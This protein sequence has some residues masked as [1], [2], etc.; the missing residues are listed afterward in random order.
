MT[1]DLVK[2]LSKPIRI[3]SVILTILMLAYVFFSLF[4][5]F[6]W[7]APSLDGRLDQH[8]AADSSTYIYIADV[9]RD[10]RPDPSVAVALAS[11]PN[12]LWVPVLLALVLKSTFA[13]VIA[14]Y[15]MFILALYLFKKSTPCSIATL[16]GLLLLNATTT[17]S[18]LSVNKE[19]VDLLVVSLFIFARRKRSYTLLF[20]VLLLALFNRFEV[21]MV[22]FLFMFVESRMNP[23]RQNR[24][25][26]IIVLLVVLSVLLPLMASRTLAA[27][28][29]EASTSNTI[30]FLDILEMHYLYGLAVIPKIAENL[31]AELINVSKW[32]HSYSLS[33]LAN[34]YIV[35]SNNLATF[36][37]FIVLSS[38]RAL[39]LRS[40]LIYFAT[41]GS[42][43][44][45][46]ALVVQ[47]RY[48]Y[49]VYVVL[50]L[51]AA[52]PKEYRRSGD[53]RLSRRCEE[54]G[55]CPS[56]S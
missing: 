18:L 9:L 47:P 11:F 35:L 29:E 13:M 30:T 6:Q 4:L 20:L 41:L 51:Q 53:I 42:I 5:F 33:D 17:I 16:A 49:F 15:A 43:I 32:V 45:A 27:H 23:W 26:T 46:I 21:C 12:T 40:D 38:R 19:I 52:L 10:G 55:G 7:V 2:I 37:V 56:C 50:C 8:I 3:R 36:V 48:F 28:F 1:V 31:F 39:T 25:L 24:R 34:S 54:M 14:D 44:M 22:L